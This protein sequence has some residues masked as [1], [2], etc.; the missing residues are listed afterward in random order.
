MLTGPS[1]VFGRGVRVGVLLVTTALLLVP[2]IVR[3]RQHLI[4]RDDIRPSVRLN[5]IGVTP[6][7]DDLAQRA[8]TDALELPLASR[9]R[10]EAPCFLARSF[11]L[12]QPV[13]NSQRD[14]SP[15]VLRGPPT[16]L[17]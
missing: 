7:K 5:W 16:S 10:S 8:T 6:P 15:C 11:A 14:N 3:A 13:P 1:R 4:P 9:E 12:D 2:A 17:A